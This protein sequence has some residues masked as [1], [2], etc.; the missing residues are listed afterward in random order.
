M[1]SRIHQIFGEALEQP[2]AGRVAWLRARCEGEQTLIHDVSA[3]LRADARAGL[4][5]GNVAGLAEPLMTQ[6]QEGDE[7]ILRQHVGRNFG[8]YH[9][10]ELLGRGG[11]GSVWRAERRD[12]GFQ[13]QVAIKLLASA[14]PSEEALQR[15]S[16][17]RQILARLQHPNIARV[18]DGGSVDGAPWFAMDLVEGVALDEYA[19]QAVL[20]FEQ[21]LRVFARVVG[22]VQFAHQNLI[23]HRDLKPSNILVDASGEPKLLDFGVAKLLDEG[24]DLTLSRAPLSMAYAAPEQIVGKTITTATDIYSLGV[25]LYELL[26]GS[27]PHKARGNSSLALMQAITDTDPMPP[28]RAA[29]PQTT[30]NARRLRGDLDT[31]VLKCLNRD[32]AR[33]YASAQAL[34]DDIEAYLQQL[35]IRARPESWRYRSAKFLRRHWIGSALTAAATLALLGTTAFSVSQARRAN[36][37]A[38][39]AS[40]ERDATL[41][42]ARHQ[43]ALSEHFGAVLNRAAASGEQVTVKQL[44]AWAADP[45]LLGDFGDARMQRTI[46]LAVANLLVQNNEFPEAL[47]LLDELRPQLADASLRDR[48]L[49]LDNRTLALIRTGQLDAAQASLDD[50]Q[51]LLPASDRGFASAQLHNY[52]AQLLRARGELEAAAQATRESGDWAAAAADASPLAR[53]DLI[54]SAANGLLQLGDLNGAISH[55]ETALKIWADAQV[56]QNASLPSLLG[57]APSARFLR[58]DIALALQQLDA[59]AHNPGAAE[60]IPSHAAR[61]AT[62]AKALALL[63]RRDEALALANTAANAMCAEV[64]AASLDC[65]RMRISQSETARIAG[66]FGTA[67]QLLDQVEAQLKRQPIPALQGPVDRFRLL[68]AILADPQPAKLDALFAVVA[69]PGQSGLPQRNAL[70]S[71]LVLAEQLNALG[72]AAAATRCAEIAIRVGADLKEHGGMDQSLLALWQARL[73][74][75]PVPA[76]A[77]AALARA[78]GA[79]HPWVQ[80]HSA[81]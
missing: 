58:G 25:I 8:P 65:L 9:V 30:R 12:G 56:S 60:S 26:S 22:A 14:L 40:A 73:Q 78:I 45:G 24:I 11:M 7:K 43:E 54:G 13:Q 50:A 42:E 36:E 19:R 31:I 49:A 63:S 28:S 2:D 59:L 39:V 20:S 18:L 6:L 47:K 76:K 1:S 17:E 15:F 16:R 23:V 74:R 37:A 57:V 75:A 55:A 35:P 52:R 62:R 51:S 68:L 21:T 67:V 46:S 48:L 3:L 27:R 81:G 53:G 72:H 77:L 33:R 29:G 71:L 70:R 69:A 5:D 41:A 64:G 38:R 10:I 79:Q 32:P 61:D 34:A 66:D 80:A 44:L 4:L